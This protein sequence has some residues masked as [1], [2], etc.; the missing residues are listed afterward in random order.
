MQRHEA[1][2]SYLTWCPYVRADPGNRSHAGRR[3]GKRG[4]PGADDR[5]HDDGARHVTV[6]VVAHR[7][8]G[9]PDFRETHHVG[10]GGGYLVGWRRGVGH[11]R[12]APAA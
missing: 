11:H 1:E 4:L 9:G 7:G 8:A 5:V 10:P 2:R 12:G 6:E 3:D